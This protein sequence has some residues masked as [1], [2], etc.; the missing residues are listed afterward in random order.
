M[1]RKLSKG[2]PNIRTPP[3]GCMKNK[4][5]T[6]ANCKYIIEVKSVKLKDKV[7]VPG[8]EIVV[9]IWIKYLGK[10]DYILEGWS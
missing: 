5:R 7:N 3:I 1:P 2:R 10:A 4:L 6:K 8:E 9:E